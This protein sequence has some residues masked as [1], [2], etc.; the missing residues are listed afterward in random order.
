M[1]S[2]TNCDFVDIVVEMILH[3]ISSISKLFRAWSVILI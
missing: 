2:E 3:S 1:E